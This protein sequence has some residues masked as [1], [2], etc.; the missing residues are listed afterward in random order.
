MTR[1]LCAV[2]F[3]ALCGSSHDGVFHELIEGIVAVGVCTAHGV[4]DPSNHALE[5]IVATEAVTQFLL[6]PRQVAHGIPVNALLLGFFHTGA[7]QMLWLALEVKVVE[8]LH[9]H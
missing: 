3:L 2:V 7:G 1:Q 4:G 5:V 6:A 9:V 8:L